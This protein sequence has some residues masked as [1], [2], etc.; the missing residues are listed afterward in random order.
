MIST[1]KLSEIYNKWGDAQKLQPLG[2]ALE[3]AMGNDRISEM[4][5]NWLFR[6]IDVWEYAQDKEDKKYKE[7][8]DIIYGIPKGGD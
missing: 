7:L 5:R 8:K 2:C 3:E 4:Q 6:F 1:S